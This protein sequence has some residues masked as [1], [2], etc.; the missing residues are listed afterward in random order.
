[1]R[2]FTTAILALGLS[3]SLLLAQT[4][5]RPRIGLVAHGIL[6]LHHASFG[7]LPDVGNCCPSFTG[8]TGS[9][10]LFGASYLTGLSKEWL[11]DV[12]A[13]YQTGTADLTER[14][15]K[16][17]VQPT[18]QFESATI[19]HDLSASFN[20]LA[21]EPL[22]IYRIT[23]TVGL[24]MGLWG[25]FQMDG[26]FTQSE[27]LETPSNVVFE[28][29][30]R[31]RNRAEG[32]IERIATMNLGLTVGIGADFPLDVDRIFVA[33]PEVLLTY[34]PTALVQDLSWSHT[35]IRA[36]VVISYS[37]IDEEEP[38]SDFEL[39]EVARTS[40]L[41]PASETLPARMISA[42]VSGLNESGTPVD[43]QS[44][45]IEEFTS[46]RIRPLL[47]FVFFDE[48]SFTLSPRYRQLSREQV[49][50]YSLANFYNLD[51]MITYY[52]LL[53]VVGKRMQ[54][55][56]EATVT[57]T[58]CTD[59]KEAGGSEGLGTR[60]AQVVKN[61]LVDTWQISPSRITVEGRELPTAASNEADLDGASENRRVEISSS[62]MSVLS[63][64]TSNDTMRVFD[65]PGLRFGLS[66]SD[67]S[68]LKSWTLFVS[69]NDRII[70]TFH[71]SKAPPSSVDWRMSE[72]AA[73]IS[74]GTRKLEYMLVVQDS[75]NDVIPSASATIPV[76]ERTLSDKA[77][78]GGTDKS[79]DRFSLILFGFDRSDLTDEH[80]QLVDKVKSRLSPTSTVSI[81]GYTDRTGSED[82]NRKL[83]EQRARAVSSALGFQRASVAG[84]GEQ[85]PLYD[86]DTPEG[87]FYSRTVEIIVETPNR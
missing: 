49:E 9:G 50:G 64:V 69:E 27:T 36:G 31:T 21:I 72:Q 22:A 62:D 23:P 80:R 54:E 6:D 33:S 84:N 76:T 86:N 13:G 67:T 1:M 10:L 52:Q 56:P 18:G 24:R 79:I 51:A 77:S 38:I 87:R 28:N 7:Q 47:P 78:G 45:R 43:K 42:T 2:S 32:T 73:L 14:E 16:L 61:Y 58:G 59:S 26:T 35:M 5:D 46:N 71:G 66:V 55:R 85:L 75:S 63:A 83:S 8:G 68:K 17:I 57:L 30:T 19:R 37:P 70:R 4:D 81:V 53:N 40:L 15:S 82:Y 74:R 34:A 20:R 29:G 12:R 48:G 11:L 65:P 41:R 3:Y 44:V 60:R 25:G 39:F